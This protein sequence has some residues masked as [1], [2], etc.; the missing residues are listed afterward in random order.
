MAVAGPRYL[1][2]QLE[3]RYAPFYSRTRPA[4]AIEIVV[5]PG[6]FD[7]PLCPVT[8]V[9][10]PDDFRAYSYNFRLHFQAGKALV[11]AADDWRA[12]DAAMRILTSALF[13]EQNV[14]MLHAS[15]V[16]KSG[17]AYVFCGPSEAGKTTLSSMNG[18]GASG[19]DELVCVS[20]DEDRLIVVDTPFWNTRPQ[21]FAPTAGKGIFF[22]QQD[23]ETF[24]H[25]LKPKE[26]LIETF[27]NAFFDPENSRQSKQA[28]RACGALS[29]APAYCF[30][31]NLQEKEVW[32]CL[33]SI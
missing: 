21:G 10:A 7:G 28:L 26:A 23:T 32:D 5:N 25:R 33:E 17:W 20:A 3:E 4:V 11:E 31:F 12:V 15:A 24:A 18:G 1:L 27:S 6:Q 9:S 22:L 30:H 8:T 29:R 13:L 16:V 2:D 19:S 14:L